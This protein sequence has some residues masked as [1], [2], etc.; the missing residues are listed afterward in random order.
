MIANKLREWSRIQ[1][2]RGGPHDNFAGITIESISSLCR[3][4]RQSA[5]PALL[6]VTAGAVGATAAAWYNWRTLQMRGYWSPEIAFMMPVCAVCLLAAF[7]LLSLVLSGRIANSGAP[8]RRWMYTAL[9]LGIVCGGANYFSMEHAEAAQRKALD[10]RMELRPSAGGGRPEAC[11][12][13]LHAADELRVRWTLTERSRR[14]NVHA[15]RRTERLF[16]LYPGQHLVTQ[17]QQRTREVSL[18]RT[19]TGAHR[20]CLHHGAAWGGQPVKSLAQA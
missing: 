3:R 17:F 12:G 19:H 14:L 4:P 11:H 16:H 15:P 20:R 1:L 9:V 5:S 18:R 7:P 13:Q 2:R 8:A 6:V 10:R